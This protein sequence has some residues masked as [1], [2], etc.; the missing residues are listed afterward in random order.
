MSC[1]LDLEADI[2]IEG[3]FTDG[4]GDAAPLHHIRPVQSMMG[5]CGWVHG[6]LGR[7]AAMVLARW[8]WKMVMEWQT[9][10]GR[11]PGRGVVETGWNVTGAGTRFCPGGPPVWLTRCGWQ[12]YHEGNSL[13][14]ACDWMSLIASQSSEPAG[15]H[16]IVGAGGECRRVSL[17]R[18]CRRYRIGKSHDPIV[19]ETSYSTCRRVI[20][21]L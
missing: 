4:L 1:H 12:P 7:V 11:R 17:G 10:R 16:G 21:G 5:G 19:G 13:P 3:G 14:S 20:C 2:P 18:V 15:A 6:L 8:R 9:G